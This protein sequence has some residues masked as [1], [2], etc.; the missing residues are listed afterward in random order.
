MGVK[1]FGE[2]GKESKGCTD[3]NSRKIS[4]NS[5]ADRGRWQTLRI[6]FRR[7]SRERVH[8]KSVLGEDTNARGENEPRR[9]APVSNNG[10]SR[11][12]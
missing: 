3:I 8:T 2:L 9:G 1:E 7:L 11:G 12:Q 6:I 10:K 4:K 5:G